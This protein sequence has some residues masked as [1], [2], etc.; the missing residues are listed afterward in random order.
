MEVRRHRSSCHKCPRVA[1]EHLRS[2]CPGP[3][4]LPRASRHDACHDCRRSCRRCKSSSISTASRSWGS[5]YPP[6]TD[7]K[8]CLQASFDQRRKRNLGI[9][10][11]AVVERQCN[12][13][14]KFRSGSS[15]L[16]QDQQE[17]CLITPNGG[18]SRSSPDG[19]A[20]TPCKFEINS[21]IF[22]VKRHR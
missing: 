5:P 6:G 14:L 18:L 9:A 22:P 17:R 8:S 11:I 20:P 4:R 12:R 16:I 2:R 7:E 19:M 3:D 15:N 13:I 1:S 21:F 10:G